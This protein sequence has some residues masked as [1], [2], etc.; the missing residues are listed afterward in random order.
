MGEA[1]GVDGIPAGVDF[2]VLVLGLGGGGHFG[3][4]RYR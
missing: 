1:V 2:E 4:F 3:G